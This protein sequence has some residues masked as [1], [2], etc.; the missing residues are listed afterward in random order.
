MPNL[1]AS[2]RG[3]RSDSDG[4]ESAVDVGLGVLGEALEPCSVVELG[5]VLGDE[6]VLS[7]D[8][9]VDAVHWLGG[10]ACERGDLPAPGDAVAVVEDV[11]GL[12][13]DLRLELALADIEGGLVGEG[14]GSERETGHQ[15]N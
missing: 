10:L 5:V 8:E 13:L 1:V 12:S 9:V 6:A 4:S 11:E 3:A 7:D 2:S 14:D 15:V